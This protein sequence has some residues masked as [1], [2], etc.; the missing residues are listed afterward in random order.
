M[1]PEVQLR[2]LF[3]YIDARDLAQATDLSG[4]KGGLGY[5]VFNVLN[6]D[7]SIDLENEQIL[8]DFIL[9]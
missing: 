2:N 7:N 9:I 1:E 4:E 8:K 3:N 5:E 6:D